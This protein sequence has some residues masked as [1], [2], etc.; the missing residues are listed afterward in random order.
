MTQTLSVYLLET[1]AGILHLDTQRRFVF[2]YDQ[3]WLESDQA[4]PLSLQLPLQANA[5]NDDRARPFFANLLPESELRRVIARKLGISEQNDFAL[6]EAVGGECA[7]AVS[8]FPD[9]V[10]PDARPEYR[11]LT[12]H[13]L[14]QLIEEMPGRP[15]LAGETGIRLSLAGAQNKLPVYFD[16]QQISIP[17]GGIPS[18]HILKPPIAG[19]PH[20]VENEIFCMRL[21]GQLGLPVPAVQILQ[22]AQPLYLIRRYDR[23]P[24]SSG[25]LL[26]IHQEDFCQALGVTPEAKYEIEGGPGLKDCF[27]LLREYS[28]QPAADI[29]LLLDW[30]IFNFF[31]GNADAH[32]KNISLLLTDKGPRLAPF[33]DLM[34]TAVY[35]QFA[36]RMA[37][38]TGNENRPDWIIERKW[39][40]FAEEVGVG[41][42]LVQKKLDDVSKTILDGA[43]QVANQLRGQCGD[44]DF[45]NEIIGVITMRCK[46]INR[47]SGKH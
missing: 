11:Q 10:Q 12:D 47:I 37:M 5:F 26:R 14:N 3:D 13:E 33:Y 20:S 23:E 8:L 2:Q 30:T 18:S 1:R 41:F 25:G 21:A 46:K 43:E 39:Q 6:L 31:V 19:I 40:T 44:C 32:A 28:I 16:G 36:K 45:Y 17:M 15:M 42:R 22:K 24:D 7:G 29:S 27:N 4:I 35:P 9:D 38:K 34:C